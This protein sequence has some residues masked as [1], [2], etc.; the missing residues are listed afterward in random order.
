MNLNQPIYHI[1]HLNNL[2]SIVASGG[3]YSDSTMRSARTPHTR[4]GH[5]HIK[6]RRLTGEV[7]VAAKGFLGDYVPFNFCARSVMLYA[8]NVGSVE[9]YEGGQDEVIHLVS[10]IELACNTGNSWAFTDRHAELGYARYFHSIS[11]LNEVDWNVMP[12]RQWGGDGND[13]I[14]EKRQAEFLVHQFFPWSSVAEIGVKS[15]KIAQS[16]ENL[17]RSTGHRPTVLIQPTWYY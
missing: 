6:Q 5:E 16:V 7:A 2:P 15:A 8:I 9:G 12:K 17:I 13:D 1:T 11:N 3:L 14:K 4:I 10:T